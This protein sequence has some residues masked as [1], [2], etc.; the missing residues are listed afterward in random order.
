MAQRLT[1]CLAGEEFHEGWPAA[2]S[3]L[4][5][6]YKQAGREFLGH[7]WKEAHELVPKS[8]LNELAWVGSWTSDAEELPQVSL[9]R[10]FPEHGIII[11]VDALALWS[12]REGVKPELVLA[13]Q[14]EV[15]ARR[16]VDAW[17][18]EDRDSRPYREKAHT[19]GKRH[20]RWTEMLAERL[21]ILK[22]EYER[23]YE[24]AT[25]SLAAVCVA[26]TQISVS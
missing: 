13:L 25:A 17:H 4:F 23:W 2:Y 15:A 20:E 6:I 7:L 10:V 1:R 22:P 5:R 9:K 21:E 14:A 11:L 18:K 3:K 24:N 8:A 12:S 16:L 26:M 19:S